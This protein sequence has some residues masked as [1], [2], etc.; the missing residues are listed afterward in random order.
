M[1]GPSKLP[2]AFQSAPTL[3]PGFHSLLSLVN[4]SRV[5]VKVS[6]L[7]RMSNEASSIFDELQPVVRTFA[8]EIPDRVIWGSD[9]PHTGDGHK[10]LNQTLDVKEPFRIIDDAAILERLQ[11][12]MGSDVYRKMLV[13]NPGRLYISTKANQ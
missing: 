3:Q 11:V 7:Y 9:W 1:L 2:S 12:W 10:R 5:Y 13:D 8:Q 6:G 4:E